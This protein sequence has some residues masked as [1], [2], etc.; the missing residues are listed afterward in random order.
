MALLNIINRKAKT[1][2][3]TGFGKNASNYGGR[4][5]NKDGK[6]NTKKIGVSLLTQLSSYHTMLS[7]PI[8][9]FLLLIMS[10]LIFVNIIF[11][12]I[13]YFIGID[14]LTGIHRVNSLEQFGEA[15]FFSV[16]TFTTV[17]YGRI[18]PIGWLTSSVAAFEA[19]FGLLSFAIATGLIYGR[20]S[21]PTAYLYYSDNFIIA[22]Y[23]DGRALMM[24]VAPYKNTVLLE[25]EAKVTIALMIDDNGE[26]VNRFYPVE[27][28]FAKVNALTLSWTI[29]HPIEE[30]SPLYNF[31]QEDFA[32]ADG[33]VLVFLKAFDDTFCNTVVSRSSY[34]FRDAVY[35]KKFVPMYSRSEDGGKTVLDLEKLN[36]MQDAPIIN[37]I[38]QEVVLGNS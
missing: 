19:F 13:Y 7:L 1:E 32:K 18:A 29:V 14:H 10:S 17:G 24:R 34:T 21:R 9:K 27:L 35:G 2:D 11:A 3:N 23:K 33:E 6:P 12:S 22:P 30:N 28:E 36:A 4:F 16:Q 37:K 25:A 38:S 8:W 31:T 15:F 20:F 5:L 26:K